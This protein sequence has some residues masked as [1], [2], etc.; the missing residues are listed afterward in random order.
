TDGVTFSGGEPFEQAAD[1]AVIARQAR[2]QGLNV[3]TYT[4]YTFEQLAEKMKTDKGTEE[5]LLLTDVLVDG[6]FVLAQKSFDV[7]WRGSRNQRLIDV[8]Q[9]LAAGRAVERDP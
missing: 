6:R 4:G 9:S 1:C 8:P 5:L 2:E 3:W 7:P